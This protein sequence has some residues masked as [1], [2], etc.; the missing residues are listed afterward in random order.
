MLFS[1]FETS[2]ISPREDIGHPNH[3]LYVIGHAGFQFLE[4]EKLL[5]ASG[6]G[7]DGGIPSAAGNNNDIFQRR[8][9]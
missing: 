6:A 5:A 2:T 4:F 3:I 1:H 8:N 7:S 9:G